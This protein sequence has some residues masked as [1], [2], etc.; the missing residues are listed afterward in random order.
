[1]IS[2]YIEE[3]IEVKER[4]PEA[5]EALESLLFYP[6]T[7]LVFIVIAIWLFRGVNLSWVKD[8]YIHTANRK[9]KSI[10]SLYEF[11]AKV[12]DNIKDVYADSYEEEVFFFL[13]RVRASK[14]VFR[15]KLINLYMASGP[16]IGWSTIRRAMPFINFENEVLSVRNPTRFER[17]NFVVNIFMAIAMFVLFL[18][19][20]FLFFT[21]IGANLA[22][23]VLFLMSAGFLVV[24]GYIASQNWPVFDSKKIKKFIEAQS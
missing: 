7:W 15:D 10:E 14:G 5:F 8:L 17:I 4:L 3:I 12:P 18:A 13:T 20:F 11:G 9:L 24:A 22:T 16:D 19:L 1:M 6:Y 23:P 21:N 2:E